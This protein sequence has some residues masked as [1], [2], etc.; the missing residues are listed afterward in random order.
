MPMTSIVPKTLN[1]REAI[2]QEKGVIG[3]G[4]DLIRY[5]DGFQ[6]LAEYLL[7]R[8]VVSDSM[9][10]ALKLAKKYRYSLR[11]VTL[12][13]ESLNPGGSISGGTFK[14]SGN[15]LGRHREMEEMQQQMQNLKEALDYL[16]RET[17]GAHDE[18]RGKQASD[19]YASGGLT[20]A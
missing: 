19:L 1:N 4:S 6:A 2:L 10:N 13:G 9:D 15:L 8:V 18:K 14:N 20:G 11:I 17:D 3:V 7:G 16:N 5:D 12:E